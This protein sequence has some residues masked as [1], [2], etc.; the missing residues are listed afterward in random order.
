M[1]DADEGSLSSR[2]TGDDDDDDDDDDDANVRPVTGEAPTEFQKTLGTSVSARARDARAA[3]DSGGSDARRPG[4]AHLALPDE[5]VMRILRLTLD[6]A[7]EAEPVATGL[8]GGTGGD[9]K[10]WSVGGRFRT[11]LVQ[12]IR[13]RAGGGMGAGGRAPAC[14]SRG[15]PVGVA[16]TAT[17]DDEAVTPHTLGHP[18]PARVVPRGPLREVCRQWRRL[19]DAAC[20]H[21]EARRAMVFGDDELVGLAGVLSHRCTRLTLE[22]SHMVSGRCSLTSFGLRDAAARLPALAA[23]DV[24]Q[25]GMEL[26]EVLHIAA[27]QCPALRELRVCGQPTSDGRHAH[28]TGWSREGPRPVAGR[29]HADAHPGATHGGS[30]ARGRMAT[31]T[32]AGAGGGVDGWSPSSSWPPSPPAGA[33]FPSASSSF[34]GHSCG[35]PA[36]Q[37]PPPPSTSASA[38][39]WES[40]MLHEIPAGPPALAELDRLLRAGPAG[41]EELTLRHLPELFA[42][43]EAGER[44]EGVGAGGPG[45]RGNGG[46]GSA[47]HPPRTTRQRATEPLADP[48]DWG[49]GGNGR[50]GVGGTGDFRPLHARRGEHERVHVPPAAS[51]RAGV[52]AALVGC[53]SLRSLRLDDV[54]LDDATAAALVRS[55]PAALEELHLAGWAIGPRTTAAVAS[56]LATDARPALWN[57][58]LPG[59]AMSVGAAVT[60]DTALAR[61]RGGGR[62]LF[63]RLGVTDD[64]EKA[65]TAR[66]VLVRRCLERWQQRHRAN[67]PAARSGAEAAG[68]DKDRRRPVW[69]TTGG[70]ELKLS[71]SAPV[72]E[73][74]AGD[75][76]IHA[77]RDEGVGALAR[78][79]PR[80]LTLALCHHMAQCEA[81]YDEDEAASHLRSS[82]RERRCGDSD[83]SDDEDDEDDAVDVGDVDEDGD[84]AL[85]R[86]P[87]RGGSGR[88]RRWRSWRAPR[89]WAALGGGPQ[90][91]ESTSRATWAAA[92]EWLGTQERDDSLRAW[93]A[94]AAA[95]GRFMPHA[96]ALINTI[97]SAS[98]ANLSVDQGDAARTAGEA[99]EAADR[100]GCDGDAAIFA[101]AAADVVSGATALG[102]DIQWL[103]DPGVSRALAGAAIPVALAAAAPET[104]E[105]MLDAIHVALCT[106][107]V[108]N[109]LVRDAANNSHQSAHVLDGRVTSR[110]GQARKGAEA[111]YWIRGRYVRAVGM[112]NVGSAYLAGGAACAVYDALRRWLDQS[113]GDS[114]VGLEPHELLHASMLP[115]WITAAHGRSPAEAAGAVA[116]AAAGLRALAGHE[117]SKGETGLRV[118]AKLL[119]EAARLQ[120]RHPHRGELH[121]AVREMFTRRKFAPLLRARRDGNDIISWPQW[122]HA[123]GAPPPLDEANAVTMHA[124]LSS[125]AAEY[126]RLEAEA[127]SLAAKMSRLGSRLRGLASDLQISTQFHREPA[128]QLLREAHTAMG[129]RRE[130]A[131]GGGAGRARAERPPP[132]TLDETMS[133]GGEPSGAPSSP[134]HPVQ[135]FLLPGGR[136]ELAALRVSAAGGVNVND[137]RRRDGV[138]WRSVPH[139]PPAAPT[140]LIRRPDPGWECRARGALRRLLAHCAR[141]APYVGTSEGAAREA[142]GW[143]RV[144]DVEDTSRLFT[145]T[146]EARAA[147][148][149][150]AWFMDTEDTEEEE[151]EAGETDA[152]ARCSSPRGRPAGQ[153]DDVRSGGRLE[154]VLRVLG[155]TEEGADPARVLPVRAMM[156]LRR[157][158]GRAGGTVELDHTLRRNLLLDLDTESTDA[159]ENTQRG[160]ASSLVLSSHLQNSSGY[161]YD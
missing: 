89:V 96:I 82:R 145:A 106:Q 77:P 10:T 1:A 81:F 34:G 161:P 55:L 56:A 39:P 28:G 140:T 64:D 124:H 100:G 46:W 60:L 99:V 74:H 101:A 69:P 136:L 143:S 85:G 47:V 107:L 154:D 153:T 6:P 72:D 83:V 108:A 139:A 31:G 68:K 98:A 9:V 61:R 2:Q 126:E 70:E 94:R 12:G 49:W 117:G 119:G 63:V 113:G 147:A 159:A 38:G 17:N 86:R 90:T 50:G 160:D 151:E 155:V 42:T 3:S 152:A 59:A 25:T 57:V 156:S 67:L 134:L 11:W 128:R 21:L 5:V 14:A 132:G 141:A 129:W 54:G 65:P 20:T 53:Q 33:S 138:R 103:A 45:G 52:Y 75:D 146:W 79:S 95:Y 41:L 4:A 135:S 24:E 120:P 109:D 22:G 137:R 104:P 150:L 58:S 78:W 133:G 121:D 62:A 84:E 112:R 87:R 148:A 13:R 76:E 142:P 118:L 97:A 157:K 23:L 73:I 40:A 88:S 144:D 66:G 111:G 105:T 15:N 30:N 51:Q 44:W 149:M 123:V 71:A 48:N 91:R 43:R 19:L 36:L 8:G 115:A 80:H 29:T 32:G 26:A 16:S 131:G 37:C 130:P 35:S 93:S 18:P 102:L 122:L 116:V 110:E 158:A 127:A 7:R 125:G 27:T 114:R 92:G